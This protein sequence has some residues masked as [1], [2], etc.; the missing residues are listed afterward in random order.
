MMGQSAN[1]EQEKTG[2]EHFRFRQNRV[3]VGV[4]GALKLGACLMSGG[5]A[6]DDADWCNNKN[7]PS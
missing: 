2:S 5:Q 4:G 6:V 1:K 7:I 3:G